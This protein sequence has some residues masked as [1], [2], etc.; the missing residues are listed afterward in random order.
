MATILQ[1]YV[2][3]NSVYILNSFSADATNEMLGDLAELVNNLTPCPAY[4]TNTKLTSPYDIDT[5]KNPVI[6]VYI[7]SNGGDIPILHAISTLLSIAKSKG[8]IIRTTVMGKAYSCG[9]MLAIQGTP[10]FRIMYSKAFNLVHFGTRNTKISLESEIDAS[11][12]YLKN[13]NNGVNS[14]YLEHTKITESK[15]NQLMKHDYSF[16]TAEKCL[17]LGICDW[18][19]DDKG[20]I[21]KNIIQNQ[22]TKK[23]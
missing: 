4:K 15:L 21:L 20:N 2:L 18:I 13:M 17:K 23:R 7:N 8:A 11:Q 22:K 14:L 9:S 16:L 19:I 12:K 3:N 10:G 6:D 1:N 5:S